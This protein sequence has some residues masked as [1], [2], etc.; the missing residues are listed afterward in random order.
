MGKFSDTRRHHS[1]NF[2]NI[3]KEVECVATIGSE[4]EMSIGFQAV[5]MIVFTAAM[6]DD[7]RFFA[8]YERKLKFNPG[9]TAELYESII[10]SLP[11]GTVIPPDEDSMEIITSD[12]WH[13][14]PFTSEVSETELRE[15]VKEYMEANETVVRIKAGY[16]M[17]IESENCLVFIAFI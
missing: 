16:M 1:W 3:G 13:P 2:S 6:G 15:A 5:R 9:T 8:R 7:I 14:E 4:N 12:K 10:K 11:L 17:K